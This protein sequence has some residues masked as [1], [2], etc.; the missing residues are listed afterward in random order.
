MISAR[1]LALLDAAIAAV[2]R[3][4]QWFVLP[5]ILLLFLQWPLRDLFHA[6]SREA[7]DL[8]QWLFALY[9]AMS[10]TAATRTHTHLAADILARRYPPAVRDLIARVGAALGLVLWALLVLFASKNIVFNS[11]SQLEAFP[12]T[13]NPGYF[14]IKIA[15]W[16]L[17]GLILAQAVL[18][19]AQPRPPE[20]A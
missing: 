5:V 6:Y 15:L 12:D 10:V 8:G 9:V 14:L 7:N 3:A 20:E 18:V 2:L 17:A 4:G 13:Y 19:I 16:V 11:V 1:L